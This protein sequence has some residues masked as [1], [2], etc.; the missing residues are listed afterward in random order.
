MRDREDRARRDASPRCSSSAAT[1]ARPSARRSRRR[2][3]RRLEPAARTVREA[4]LDLARA[5]SPATSRRRSRA[6]RVDV[7]GGPSGAR[8]SRAVSAPDAEVARVDASSRSSASSLASSSACARPCSFSGGSAW[9]WKRP[10]RFQSVSPWRARRIVVTAGYASRRMDLGLAT[11][12]A[13]SPARPAGSVATARLL[14]DEGARVVTCG[15]GEAPGSARR[16]RRGRSRRS[17]R[18]RAASSPRPRRSA[19]ST[20]S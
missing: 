14:A 11:A 8:R 17:R 19:V 9:P 5:S 3:S 13:S 20:C 15:R 12:S 10:S 1:R 2:P 18:A 16:A 6:A 4:L 7:T